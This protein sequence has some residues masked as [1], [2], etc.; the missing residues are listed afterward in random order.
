MGRATRHPAYSGR[1]YSNDIAV[2]VTM[3][4]KSKTTRICYILS[5]DDNVFLEKTNNNDSDGQ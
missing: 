4:I 5:F 3:W 1:T 2:I